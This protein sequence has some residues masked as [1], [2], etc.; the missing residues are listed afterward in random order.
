V[1]RQPS[2]EAARESLSD[3]VAE[4]GAEARRKYGPHIGWDQLQLL[5]QDR[6]CTR[7][8]CEIQFN[9]EPL[10]PGEFAHPMANG[11]DPQAGFVI[12]IHPQFAN[13]RDSIPALVLYQL[14]LVNYGGFASTADAETFGAAVLGLSTDEYYASVCSLADQI[15]SGRPST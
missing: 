7:Y 9:A 3:H 8:P 6:S 10:L 2:I 5:L 4:K 13:Q 12:H 14:V 1:N 11:Q 15:S